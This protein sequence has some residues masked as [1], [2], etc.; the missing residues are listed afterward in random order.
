MPTVVTT[1]QTW[2]WLDTAVRTSCHLPRVNERAR[3]IAVERIVG[4]PVD[5]VRF[6][7]T[8]K[9]SQLWDKDYFLF[10]EAAGIRNRNVELDQ[11]VQFRVLA[12]RD[13]VYRVTFLLFLVFLV[14]EIWRPSRL[15]LG[16]I[17]FLYSC[18]M[19]WLK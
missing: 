4:N 7:L 5:F 17:P 14:R 10:N 15:L 13:S 12:G 6:A 19:F 8:D 1:S 18:L 9:V 2:N 16:V 11:W 3:K